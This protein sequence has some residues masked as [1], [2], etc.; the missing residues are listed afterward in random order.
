MLL[1]VFSLIVI[2]EIQADVDIGS[3]VAGTAGYQPHCEAECK[4]RGYKN[5]H[6]GSFL[7]IKCWCDQ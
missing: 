4:R 6:C 5:G 1:S 7:R 2:E 3:C